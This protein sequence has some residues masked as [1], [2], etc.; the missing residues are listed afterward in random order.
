M[1]I[2][3][4]RSLLVAVGCLASCSG[5]F[6]DAPGSPDGGSSQTNGGTDPGVGVGDLDSGVVEPGP[7]FSFVQAVGLVYVRQGQTTRASASNLAVFPLL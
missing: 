2:F 3:S 7:T 6:G 5:S 1:K 4:I